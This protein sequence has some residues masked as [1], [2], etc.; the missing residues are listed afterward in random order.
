M[1][2]LFSRLVAI[3]YLQTDPAKNIQHIFRILPK[4]IEDSD[5]DVRRIMVDL[6]P[7]L[8]AVEEY[9]AETVKELQDWTEVSIF[10]WLFN[11]W[12]KLFG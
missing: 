4:A 2:F 5:D 10:S 6:C 8:L 1:R 3:R 11:G 12:D 7:M 9:A